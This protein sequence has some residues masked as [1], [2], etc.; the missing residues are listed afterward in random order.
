MSS[1][2]DGRPGGLLRLC[3]S[4]KAAAEPA[5]DGR[6]EVGEGHGW[7]VGEGGRTESAAKAC[8]AAMAKSATAKRSA[9]RHECRAA[10]DS[11]GPDRV[12]ARNNFFICRGR[13]K[14]SG[15]RLRSVYFFTRF[16]A[17]SAHTTCMVS[18]GDCCKGN[19]WARYG[20]PFFLSRRNWPDGI[21]VRPVRD[22]RPALATAPRDKSPEF[23]RVLPVLV[24]EIRMTFLPCVGAPEAV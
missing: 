6:M 3:G 2:A 21:S 19:H 22:C 18:L 5:A 7:T 17:K 15:S 16:P 23:C 1:G 10:G 24:G 9:L 11:Q 12:G 14:A 8:Y 4:A 20:E 13:H